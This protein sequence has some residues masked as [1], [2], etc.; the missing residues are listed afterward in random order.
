MENVPAQSNA[1]MAADNESDVPAVA[2]GQESGHPVLLGFNR[3][4][5][6]RQAA[7]IGGV[8]LVIARSV[9]IMVWTR[10]PSD[11]SLIHRLQAHNA[12]DIIEVLR[13]GGKAFQ[14]D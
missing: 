10:D 11:K 9:A 8:A 5:I 6:V 13:R 14:I 2:P 1:N 12:Q 3:L 7:V 4:S